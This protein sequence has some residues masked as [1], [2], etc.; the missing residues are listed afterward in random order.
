MKTA[1]TITA[2]VA[3]AV[4]LAVWSWPAQE[5]RVVD[6]PPAVAR[7]ARVP[8]G[9]FVVDGA[10]S[11]VV[12][13]PGVTVVGPV[14]GRALLSADAG[15]PYGDV[16]RVAESLVAAGASE[17]WLHVSADTAAPEVVVPTSPTD[18]AATIRMQPTLPHS[19]ALP[20]GR[21][22]QV[23]S[24]AFGAAAV[25]LDPRVACA[26]LE[27]RA[28]MTAGD[29]ATIASQLAEVGAPLV[30]LSGGGAAD[31]TPAPGHRV[32]ISTRDVVSAVPIVRARA[33]VGCAPEEAVASR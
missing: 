28:D 32:V 22:V 5:I 12:V 19:V 15:A 14:A 4:G 33:W 27:G 16:V 13:D 6:D 31:Q 2:F 29:L 10:P 7:A 17:V 26:R 9:S 11:V 18:V 21:V 20:D 30:G 23:A 8:V 1:L 25:A 3:L 24:G